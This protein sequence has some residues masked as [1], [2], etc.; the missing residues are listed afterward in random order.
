MMNK[1]KKIFSC[2]CAFILSITLINVDARHMR[3]KL[4]NKF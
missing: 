2:M 3:L 4:M 1:I